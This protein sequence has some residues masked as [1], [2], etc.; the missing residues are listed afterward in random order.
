MGGEDLIKDLWTSVERE[1]HMFYLPLLLSLPYKIPELEALIFF[2]IRIVQKVKKIII[3]I[4]CLH[5]LQA[6]VELVFRH[7]F[8]G[9]HGGEEL[10]RDSKGFSVVPCE[11]RFLGGDFR[12]RIDVGSIK[13]CEAAVQ[14]HIYHLAGL[15]YVDGESLSW[16]AHKP[17]AKFSLHFALL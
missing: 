2:V 10:C 12:T 7:F 8:C 16:K 15:L 11:K 13:I 9:D 3:N 5:T 6:L 4:I 1:A 17:E 14:K